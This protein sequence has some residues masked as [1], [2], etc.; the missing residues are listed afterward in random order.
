VELVRVRRRTSEA[1]TPRRPRRA[2]SRITGPAPIP[3]PEE[4]SPAAKARAWGAPASTAAPREDGSVGW[5]LP[6]GP[7]V[8]V[9]GSEP[10]PGVVDVAEVADVVSVGATSVEAEPDGSGTVVAPGTVVAALGVVEDDAVEDGARGAVVP[11]PVAG[12]V[13]GAVVAGTVVTVV[14]VVAATVVVV[15]GGGAASTT[16]VPAIPGAWKAHT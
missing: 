10:S 7:V 15:V 4:L 3:P 1:T 12:A 9:T 5:S 6:V 14:V 16:T 11:G 13:V 8:A 2:A